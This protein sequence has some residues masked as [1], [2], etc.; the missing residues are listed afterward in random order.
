MKIS[1]VLLFGLLLTSA[2]ISNC[3]AQKTLNSDVQL[4]AEYLVINERV[5]SLITLPVEIL[6][7]KMAEVD[8]ES[9]GIEV[10]LAKYE[11]LFRSYVRLTSSSKKP[12]SELKSKIQNTEMKSYIE[13]VE[14]MLDKFTVNLSKAIEIFTEIDGKPYRF[15]ARGEEITELIPVVTEFKLA[16]ES[17]MKV[18][19]NSAHRIL[20]W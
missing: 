20:D 8:V 3:E 1:S 9:L 12:L 2:S 17:M 18:V 5:D 14:R 15:I 13:S 11:S 7:T 6:T 16:R 4:I 19:N 10:A